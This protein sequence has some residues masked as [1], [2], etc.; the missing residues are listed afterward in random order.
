[1]AGWVGG[2]SRSV[3]HNAVRDIIHHFCTPL[4]KK[5]DSLN[6]TERERIST[7]LD[8]QIK[9]GWVIKNIVGQY[10]TPILR[11]WYGKTC[12]EARNKLKGKHSDTYIPLHVTE[13]V[14]NETGGGEKVVWRNSREPIEEDG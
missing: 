5:W 2:E 9:G 1:M 14:W 6:K 13:D 7:Q 11:D 12:R 10:I 8:K 4:S 3:V